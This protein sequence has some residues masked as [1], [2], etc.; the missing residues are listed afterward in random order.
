MPPP[1][2]L[3]WSGPVSSPWPR[4]PLP[5]ARACRARPPWPSR[6]D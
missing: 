4:P 1:G 3:A 6:V 5:L 2:D